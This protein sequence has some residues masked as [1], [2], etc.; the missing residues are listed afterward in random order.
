MRVFSD[1]ASSGPIVCYQAGDDWLAQ[2]F[3][4][5]PRTSPHCLSCTDVSSR[6]ATCTGND[7]AGNTCELRADRSGCTVDAGD[8]SYSSCLTCVGG[9]ASM[10]ENF[11]AVSS[12]VPIMSRAAGLLGPLNLFQCPLDGCVGQSNEDNVTS[13]TG[14][15]SGYV[16]IICGVCD[17]GYTKES[18]TCIQCTDAGD[19]IAVAL[20]LMAV[21]VLL[22]VMA[23]CVSTRRKTFEKERSLE[24]LILEFA[25]GSGLIV[26]GKVV[27]GLLQIV[28]E[29][30]VALSVVFPPAFASL[31][32]GIRVLMLDVFAI[33]H[34]DCIGTMS[35]H[36]KFALIMASPWFCVVFI[37]FVEGIA[38]KRALRSD[39]PEA[40]AE[41][42]SQA[43][44]KTWY[45]V[46][47]VFFLLFPLLSKTVFHM[48]LCQA[49]GPSENWHSD[50]L[51]VDCDVALHVVFEV[52]ATVFIFVSRH[53]FLCRLLLQNSNCSFSKLDQLGLRPQVYPVGIPLMFFTLLRRDE[54]R[55]KRTVYAVDTADTEGEVQNEENEQP[56]QNE[57]RHRSSMKKG[58]ET[59]EDSTFAFLRQDYKPEYYYFECV[60][61]VEKLI[62]TGLIIFVSRHTVLCRLLLQ[63]SFSKLDQLSDCDRRSTPAP[64]FRWH[65]ADCVKRASHYS[66]QKRSLPAA[67]RTGCLRDRCRLHILRDRGRG[68]ALC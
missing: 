12:T 9:V 53:P 1:D 57:G 28:T 46:F 13:L 22:L 42:R 41:A 33:F 54:R 14:C 67:L 47:F 55:R 64:F 23:C 36:G 32:K 50:D 61:L 65:H 48:F 60:F 29:L 17:V 38:N 25:Y 31:L 27:I 4:A 11:A 59:T 63:N 3:P 66:K 8:C 5:V 58:L 52:V 18:R 37:L 20:A 49:L 62:L 26:Q 30:P 35:V 16:G 68:M 19:S 45:R 56:R 24:I 39:T 2:D 15:E 40:V 51:S 6:S 43:R 10:N 21:A 7:N 34:V 44:G